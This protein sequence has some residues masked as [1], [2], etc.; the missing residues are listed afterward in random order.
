MQH[1]RTWMTDQECRDVYTILGTRLSDLGLSWVLD[2]VNQEIASGY[3]ETVDARPVREVRPTPATG[4]VRPGF[5]QTRGRPQQ[6]IRTVGFPPK[7]QLMLLIEA[8]DR[9]VVST[10]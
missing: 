8:I 9:S 6:F 10:V 2:A 4:E 7:E 5:E 1:R 3:D